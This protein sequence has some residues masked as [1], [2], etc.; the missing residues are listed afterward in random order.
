MALTNHLVIM[1]KEPRI[2][3]V[4]TRLARDI[5]PVAAWGFYRR[6]LQS[7][8]GS[9]T[10][11]QR[12]TTWLAVSPDASIY[13]DRLWPATTPRISQGNGDL[14]QRMGRIMEVM[15]PGPVV[16]IGADIPDIRADHIAKAFHHLGDHDAV[17]GPADDGGYWLVGLK[18]R[19]RLAQVFANVRWSTEHALEDT[20]ANLPKGARI[21]FLETLNDIDDGE[22]L[23]GH[24]YKGK[25]Q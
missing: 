23:I 25:H 12:W 17:F 4:K 11:D 2:G 9:L 1:A 18:R 22:D 14:G 3:R 21:A 8:S 5:G 16:I 10:A 20:S 7:I 24:R 15:G 13:T 6:T 19:P